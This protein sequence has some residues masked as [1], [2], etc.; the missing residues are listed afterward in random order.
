MASRGTKTAL[1]ARFERALRSKYTPVALAEPLFRQFQ[2]E[3]PRTPLPRTP[4]DREPGVDHSVRSER[5]IYMPTPCEPRAVSRKTPASC[6]CPDPR[7]APSEL[8]PPLLFR[9]APK[10]PLGRREP[11]GASL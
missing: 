9:S 10:R 2:H 3:V 8:L 11:P 1:S 7:Q 5:P 4:L 6:R